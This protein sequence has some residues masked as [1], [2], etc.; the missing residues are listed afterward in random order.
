VLS[1]GLGIP[2]YG[3][4]DMPPLHPAVATMRAPYTQQLLPDLPEPRKK[5]GEE[6]GEE[7]GAAAKEEA[8]EEEAPPAAAAQLPSPGRLRDLRDEDDSDM[9]EE[10]VAEE[11]PEPAEVVVSEEE[12]ARSAGEEQPG[13]EAEEAEEKPTGWVG[14]AAMAEWRRLVA[15]ARQAA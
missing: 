15:A 1:L 11:A 2:E 4:P 3:N 8:A 14:Q 10:E 13:E 12:E 7:E 5:A 6:E 9:A